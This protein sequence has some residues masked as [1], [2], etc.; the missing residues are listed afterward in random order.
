MAMLEEARLRI[1]NGSPQ[2]KNASE[3]SRRRRIAFRQGLKLLSVY[4]RSLGDI[5]L[6][7]GS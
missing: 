1:P 5:I 7:Q 4:N 3:Y 2:C 6:L